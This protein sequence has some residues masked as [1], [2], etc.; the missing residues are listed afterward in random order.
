MKTEYDQLIR[1]ACIEYLPEYYDWR[2]VKAQ[3]WQESRFQPDAL[4]P[5]GACGIAQIMPGTWRQYRLPNYHSPFDPEQSIMTGARYMGYLYGQWSWPRPEIDRV[6]L[7]LA[8]YNAGLGHILDAQELA[9]GTTNYA[10]T[11][12][13]LDQVTGTHSLETIDYVKKILG[14]YVAEVTR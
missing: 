9:G 4:S 10:K 11:I 3:Y 6:C 12:A 2:M 1:N 8:S 7:T 14:F 13:K 5:A